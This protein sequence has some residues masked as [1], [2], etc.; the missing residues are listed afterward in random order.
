MA[1]SMLSLKS[2]VGAPPHLTVSS[3]VGY[4]ARVT[5]ALSAK[6]MTISLKKKYFVKKRVFI[7]TGFCRNNL[8]LLSNDK[9]RG[10]PPGRCVGTFFTPNPLWGVFGKV[11]DRTNSQTD[12]K[13]G[14]GAQR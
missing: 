13:T 4:P 11:V 1:A 6:K 7:Y 2:G 14:A 10:H 3:K 8:V 9:E 5:V 12:L